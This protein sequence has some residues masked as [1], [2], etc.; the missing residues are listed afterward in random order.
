MLAEGLSLGAPEGI[1]E[2]DGARIEALGVMDG[3]EEGK[4]DPEG[5]DDP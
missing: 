3:M 2:P 1:E 5:K 4:E